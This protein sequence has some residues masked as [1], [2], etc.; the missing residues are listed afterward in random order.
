MSLSLT[1]AAPTALIEKDLGVLEP[2]GEEVTTF[3]A[4]G[5]IFVGLVLTYYGRKMLKAVLFICGFAVG[6]ILILVLT[7][8]IS[9]VDKLTVLILAGVVGII[10][11]SLCVCALNM[12]KA[13]LAGG[14]AFTLIIGV[15]N[16]GVISAIG[17]NVFLWS[18]L[19]IVLL[20]ALFFAYKA[21][22]V[23]LVL[24]TAVCGGF[25]V[26][27]CI[28]FLANEPVNIIG[29][30]V[31]PKTVLC[32]RPSCTFSTVG[33]VLLT[34]SGSLVQFKALK[35]TSQENELEDAIIANAELGA[36]PVSNLYKKKRELKLRKALALKRLATKVRGKK[37]IKY[38]EVGDGV[39]HA[40]SHPT[41]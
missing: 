41:T 27:I 6:S 26:C 10:S 3:I 29:S 33:W 7:T 18:L 16:T 24:A 31:S 2:L 9:N 1:T 14:L 4:I 23:M 22:E 35:K 28:T 38:E 8:N 11:G 32:S 20:G 17:S 30:F 13:T 39:D 21:W 34:L 37:R 12:G 15:V 19:A 40:C 25:V 5:M 36:V